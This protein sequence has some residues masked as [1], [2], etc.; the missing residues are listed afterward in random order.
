VLRRG[1]E[2][3]RYFTSHAVVEELAM[4][5]NHEVVRVPVEFFKTQSGGIA[6]DDFINGICEAVPYGLGSLLVHVESRPEWLLTD[7]GSGEGT[8]VQRALFGK[9]QFTKIKIKNKMQ[10]IKA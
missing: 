9:L 6:K 8:K 2:M 4:F 7:R 10:M 5:L 3:G 1:G